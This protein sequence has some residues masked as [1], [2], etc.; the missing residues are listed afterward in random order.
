MRKIIKTLTTICS[1]V[2]LVFSCK[3]TIPEELQILIKNE[4]DNIIHVSLYANAEYS[5]GS[6][7]YRDCDFGH[8][9]TF[10]RFSLCPDNSGL[11]GLYKGIFTTNN[12]S[13]EPHALALRVFDSIH[14]RLANNDSVI[15]KFIHEDVIGYSENLFSE[16]SKWNF[17]VLNENRPDFAKR[18]VNVHKYIFVI[19][20]NKINL[21][22]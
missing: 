9:S 22:Q 6:E 21:N 20:E 2:L 4:T 13:T 14:I 16:D 5:L 12:L 15:I 1:A 18:T 3:S 10:S 17:E 11:F 8:R 19:S 7:Y